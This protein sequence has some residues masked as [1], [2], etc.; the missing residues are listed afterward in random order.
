MENDFH[1]INFCLIQG[2]E[3]KKVYSLSHP[4]DLGDKDGFFLDHKEAENK[5]ADNEKAD[6]FSIL[7][8]LEQYRTC[9]GEFHFKICYPELIAKF[10]FPCNEWTQLTNPVIDYKIKD[11]K[12]INITFQSETEDFKGLGLA[13]KGNKDTLI[14]DHPFLPTN[15]T[16]SIGTTKG[17][18]GKIPGPG[19]HLVEK[20]ELFVNTGNGLDQLRPLVNK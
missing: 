11:F 9:S 5:N 17:I 6:M 1:E 8:Q 20:V 10:P 19:S 7:Y 16:F 15:R 12:P 13:A 4:V 14:D 18:E 3:W 2:I